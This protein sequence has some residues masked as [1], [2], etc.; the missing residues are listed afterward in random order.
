MKELIPKE[1]EEQENLVFWLEM[2]GLK[3]SA[4]PNGTYNPY[5]SQQRKNA[6]AGLRPGLP[7]LLIIIPE[8]P[9]QER[10]APSLLWIE[11]KRA[12]KSLSKVSPEQQEWIDR[13]N[14]IPNVEAVVCYG[15]DQAIAHIEEL[16]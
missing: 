5:V 12:K 8:N 1:Q 10:F 4:I 6:H 7:D 13:L 16:L 2:K 11:M 9:D 3:F 15:C 14:G